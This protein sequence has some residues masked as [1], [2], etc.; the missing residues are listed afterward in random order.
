ME[1]L[2]EPTPLE[3]I[4]MQEEPKVE[5]KSLTPDR[6]T[7]LGYVLLALS[8][9]IFAAVEIA[10]TGVRS[11]R[12]TIFFVHYIIAF[13]YGGILLY[14]DSYKITQCW[15]EVYL[16]KTVILLNLWL[17]SC[18]AL[19]R[20]LP[21]FASSVTWLSIYIIIMSAVLLSY[22]YLT[23][24]P[25]YVCYIHHAL[26][27]SGIMFYL[28]MAI[29]TSSY[30]VFGAIGTILLG[31]GA[32]IFIPAALLSSS[33]WMVIYT[34]REKR[35]GIGWIG[36]GAAITLVFTINFMVMW[37]TRVK[38]IDRLANQSVMHVDTGL[39]VWLTIAKSIQNDWVMEAILKSP[40]VYT[41]F[42]G[43]FQRDIFGA[44]SWTEAKKHD[45]LVFIS[46][47]G[48]IS[49]LS[50]EDR[51]S[52]LS[53]ITNNRHRSETRL[54]SGD[55]LTTSNIITDV[56][57]YSNLRI[58]Y[59]ELYM[60][61]RNNQPEGTWRGFNE[62]AIYT[63]ELPQGSV[64]TS[65][66]LWINGKEQ[67]GILTSKQKATEAYTTIV[68]VESRDP[69]V[70][71]WQEGNTIT[72][73]VFPCTPEEESKVKIGITTPLAVVGDQFV[74][75]NITFKGPT[76]EAAMQ[77]SRIRIFGDALNF[78]IPDNFKRNIKGEYVC[79]GNYDPDLA[80]AFDARPVQRNQFTFDGF[81]Y[82]IAEF[83]PE[84][85][86]VTFRDIYLDLNNA[87]TSDE[88]KALHPLVST[89]NVYA[90]HDGQFIA[91]NAE[92]WEDATA[93]LSQQNFSLFPFH[94]LGSA[95]TSLVVTKGRTLSPH[96]RDFGE[97]AFAKGVSQY[98]ASGK[99]VN[100]F[101]L[102]G[103]SST[104]I[105]SLNEFR[106]FNFTQ[107]N[108]D[109]LI[110]F[111]KE[112]KFPLTEESENKVVLHESGIAIERKP[113]TND[114]A[115]NNAPDHLAR[116]FAYNDIMRK[117]GSNYFKDDF[118]NEELV[119]EAATAYVVSPVSSLIVL[120]TQ[121]D[122]DRFGIT[123]KENSLKNASKDS[124]GAVPEPHEWA[125][126][127]VFLLFVTFQMFR[128]RKLKA[129]PVRK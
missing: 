91:V 39:P 112:K 105:K 106:A 125:L 13:I 5:K 128:Y 65:L 19:N 22:Q 129:V 60:N 35:L 11:D 64:V 83:K 103:G 25:K 121:Q 40:Y 1:T 18:Y 50:R 9:S 8:F 17:V 79:D 23:A 81:Q 51:M 55:Y 53:A 72:V 114:A 126:I 97:S 67:K 82:S 117:V 36:L 28:Y 93:E 76:A 3:T 52:I 111:L 98:F 20:E 113:S 12:L 75:K 95:N 96:V 2:A 45:P 47:S 38:E 123:D 89:H 74:Y 6:H 90:Y 109:Q 58:A 30:Y 42:D 33:I 69:S 57:I 27:G 14:S 78:K 92:N 104:Y 70:V 16:H 43:H 127:I 86:S 108:T 7:I 120:E 15:R 56:D 84:L 116:L 85:S 115:K 122:Y 88:I 29:Y 32:L 37:N 99:K 10:G 41:N 118:I 59:T 94:K 44:G 73:R 119:D 62:E 49:S 21:V 63:F 71:H 107:G 110:G 46:S 34:H 68:G 66:S 54:W 100:V 124:S 4:S 61:I 102:E 24:L 101:G 77:S 26:L 31:I 80:I 48:G 87:W